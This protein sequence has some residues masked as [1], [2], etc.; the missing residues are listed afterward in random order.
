MVK[1]EIYLEIKK[2]IIFLY[3]LPNSILNIKEL[4]KQFNV[5][6]MPI[7]EIMILLERDNLV[8]IVPNKGVYVADINLQELK[9]IFEVRI[10]LIGLSGRLASQRITAE[11]L[12]NLKKLLEKMKQERDRK[13]LIRLDA[14]FH[15][16]LNNSTKNK[17]L[18]KSL[19]GLRNRI[20]R[21]WYFIREE[22]DECSSQIPKDFNNI[23]KALE[24]RESTKCEQILKK[25]I[26]NFMKQIK[27]S[28]Y[29]ENRNF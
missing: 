27:E 21:L 29:N 6:I 26:L 16:L 13:K 28:L 9:D 8:Y 14:K 10:F 11:E 19:E 17:T 4:A 2:R 12:N 3:Y 1:Y 24:R 7:R 20:N 5:S 23:L 25:H 18:V 22:E 15:D